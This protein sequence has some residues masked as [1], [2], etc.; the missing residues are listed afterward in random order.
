MVQL[1]SNL[2]ILNLVISFTCILFVI[3]GVIEKTLEIKERKELK[4]AYRQKLNQ[5]FK[6]VM[7]EIGESIND[8]YE[9]VVDGYNEST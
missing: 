2:L 9:E 1:I 8:C 7:N 3:A 5:E 6:Q 4:R